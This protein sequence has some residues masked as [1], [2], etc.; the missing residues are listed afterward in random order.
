MAIRFKDAVASAG[1]AVVTLADF[2]SSLVGSF[3]VAPGRT[4]VIGR[5][6]DAVTASFRGTF[7]AVIGRTGVIGS[8]L[9]NF[10]GQV[11]GAIQAF[12]FDQP[13]SPQTLTINTDFTL[14]LRDY[15][16]GA[17]GFAVTSGTLATLG[18]TLDANTGIVTGVPTALM[19]GIVIEFEATDEAGTVI[20]AWTAGPVA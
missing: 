17:T 18:L 5:Q 20:P 19:T 1:R 9:Q 3:S 14:N 16:P 4:G 13:P 7:A 6:L 15:A 12:R 10:T 11:I 2:T 8:A